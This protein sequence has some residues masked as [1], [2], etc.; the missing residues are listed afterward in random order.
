MSSAIT[1]AP[2]RRLV[3]SL[4]KQKKTLTV[5]EQCCGGL[6]Q[7]SIM[8]QPGASA[9]FRG[10]SVPYN[11]KK[12]KGLL[13]NDDALH[14]SLVSPTQ[15]FDKSTEDGYIQS[16]FDWTSMTAKAF[17]RTLDTDYAVSEG[18]AAGK[19]N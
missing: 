19:S 18:G 10:G 5:V 4:K 9:I 17:C 12:G 16:K 11:T 1:S 15:K 3:Q 8:A 6:I 13:L 7:T 14:R 2:F